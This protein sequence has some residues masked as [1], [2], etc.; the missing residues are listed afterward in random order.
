MSGRERLTYWMF[1]SLRMV[2]I[3]TMERRPPTKMTGT[4][5]ESD[6]AFAA[7]KK[8]P[9]FNPALIP[10][11]EVPLALTSMASMPASTISLLVSKKP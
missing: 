3:V 1:V 11:R 7:P 2:L 6:N 4:S 10:I 5:T 8:L 9:S